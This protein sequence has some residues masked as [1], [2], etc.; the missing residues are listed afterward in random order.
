VPEPAHRDVSQPLHLLAGFRRRRTRSR[1]G[2]VGR[3]ADR[4]A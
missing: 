2:V 4:L 1:C 3:S